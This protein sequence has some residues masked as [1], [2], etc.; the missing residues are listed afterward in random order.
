MTVKHT[1][2]EYASENARTEKLQ[3]TKQMCLSALRVLREAQK[4]QGA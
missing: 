1:R 4:K 3:E 2:P